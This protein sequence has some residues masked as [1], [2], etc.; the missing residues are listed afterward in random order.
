[1]GQMRA[2][3]CGYYGK[4]NG[5]DEALLATLLQ[6]LPETVE[7]VVLSGNPDQTR[8]RYQVESYDRFS[9]SQV[10]KALRQADAFIWGGGSLIQDV[11]STLSPFYYLGLMQLAQKLNLKTLAWAQGIGP[12]IHPLTRQVA[13]ATFANCQ[14]VSVRDRGSANLLAGWHI[15]YHLAPDP[16]WA[17]AAQPLPEF[18]A[19]PDTSIAVNLRSHSLLTSDRLSVLTRAL[20]DLQQTTQAPILLL[21]FQVNEDL[22]IAQALQLQLP[23]D[24]QILSLE[25]PRALKGVFAR[26]K[27]TIGM[28]LHALIMAS[29]EQSQCCALSYDPKVSQL[30]TELQLPGWELAQIPDQPSQIS[31]IWIDLY[32]NPNPLSS[33]QIQSLIHQT[34]THKNLLQQCLSTRIKTI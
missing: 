3:L 32:N 19:I 21:P 31:K 15:P 5:G 4:G 16:V 2:V 17:L 23:G 11:T 22:A 1:M 6:M 7:P 13:K 12:I 10:W 26:V 9:P 28:R 8:D 18:A 30:M 33:D 20:I 14:A 34:L 24:S 27:M 29:A 25:D